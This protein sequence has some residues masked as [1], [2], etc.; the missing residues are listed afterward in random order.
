MLS[1]F[2]EG[3]RNLRGIFEKAICNSTKISATFGEYNGDTYVK[4]NL[5][6]LPASFEYV[7]WRDYPENREFLLPGKRRRLIFLSFHGHLFK[8]RVICINKLFHF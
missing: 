5:T 4:Y 1:R 8:L 2:S 3:M 6:W 7:F